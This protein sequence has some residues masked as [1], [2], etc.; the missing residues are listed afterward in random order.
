LQQGHYAEATQQLQAALTIAETLPPDDPRL[1]TSLMH[2]ATLYHM[3]GQYSQAEPLYQRVL[4]LQEQMFGPEHPQLV[5]VLEAYANLQRRLHPVRSLLPWSAAN[6]MATRA[7]R[8]QQRE[9]Q[10][11]AYEP[12]GVWSDYEEAAIFRDGS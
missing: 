8:I 11:E 4:T 12:P 6:K 3:Q 7:R 1:T 2:L 5:E 10:S 9:E